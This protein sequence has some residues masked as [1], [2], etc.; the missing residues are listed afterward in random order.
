MPAAPLQMWL[1]VVV[2]VR[3]G[4]RFLLVHE[5]KH[6]EAWYLPAGKVE[7]GEALARAAIRETR[8]E[9]GV[10]I[11]L[12]GLL[13]LDFESRSDFVRQRVIF[14]ARP[15]SDEPVKKTP[16]RESLGADWFTLEEVRTLHL[17]GSD[18]VRYL[19]RIETGGPV[20]PIQFLE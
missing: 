18:V 14:L 13:G 2:V 19:E 1:F 5:R 8:E 10:N 15:D 17:R 4:R 7:A 20:L 11:V 12:E 6:G 9:A 3:L 16:D